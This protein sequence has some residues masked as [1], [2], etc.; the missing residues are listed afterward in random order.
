MNPK[1]L[2]SLA[3]AFSSLM[4]AAFCLHVRCFLCLVGIIYCSGLLDLN[5][6]FCFSM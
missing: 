3:V 2:Y 6:K 4:K 5:F 1:F